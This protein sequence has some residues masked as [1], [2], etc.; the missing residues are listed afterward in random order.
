LSVYPD[1]TS[2]DLVPA[3]AKAW[4]QQKI[5]DESFRLIFPP[6]SQWSL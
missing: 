4:V 6:G 2:G 5:L 1:S 3:A